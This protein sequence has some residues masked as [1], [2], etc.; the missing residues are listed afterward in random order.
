MRFWVRFPPQLR[1]DGTL[2]ARTRLTVMRRY[3]DQLEFKW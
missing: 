3:V 1:A 2:S